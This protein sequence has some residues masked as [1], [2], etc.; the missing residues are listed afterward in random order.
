MLLVLQPELN[1]DVFAQSVQITAAISHSLPVQ[2]PLHPAPGFFPS[3]AREE[4]S[5]IFLGFCGAAKYQQIIKTG[6]LYR[7]TSSVK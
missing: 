5:L 4:C 7:S 3:V 6:K 1:S 2:H